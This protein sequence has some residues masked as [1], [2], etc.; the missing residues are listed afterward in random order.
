M[1]W[2]W[3]GKEIGAVEWWKLIHR[4]ACQLQEKYQKTMCF[5][6]KIHVGLG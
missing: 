5:L 6:P 2:L 3:V 4:R 1:K